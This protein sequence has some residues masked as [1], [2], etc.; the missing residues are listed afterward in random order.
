[1][2]EA[3]AL[4]GLT[5]AAAIDQGGGGSDDVLGRRVVTVPALLPMAGT[6]RKAVD[7]F[8]VGHP[9]RVDARLVVDEFVTTALVELRC[10]CCPHGQITLTVDRDE[11]RVRLEVS[12]FLALSHPPEWKIDG[13]E[14][15]Q[16]NYDRGLALV[17]AFCDRWGHIARQPIRP[18]YYVD[19][20]QTWYAEFDNVT[21]KALPSPAD[22]TRRSFWDR[23]YW[24]RARLAATVRLLG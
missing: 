17:N 2:I 8:M 7:G 13:G 6:L 3:L 20:H 24:L 1:M 4:P 14:D 11:Q 19:K 15:P 21:R 12:Y 5:S 9:R 23:W 22:S 16:D 10:A 18:P